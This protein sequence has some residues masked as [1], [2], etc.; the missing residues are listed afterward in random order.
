MEEKTNRSR[1]NI[2]DMQSIQAH[3]A[4]K[5][6]T[7]KGTSSS[8]I[9]TLLHCV[10]N[11]IGCFAENEVSNII[12]NSFPCFLIVNIDSSSMPGSH[13]L[14]LGI[15][16]NQIEIF[17]PLGFNSKLWPNKPFYLLNFLHNFSFSRKLIFSV[18]IQPT[19]SFLCGFYCLFYVL[20]RQNF[21]FRNIQRKFSRKLY[22]NDSILSHLFMKNKF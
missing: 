7:K 14:A 13:W 10:P 12:F 11:F 15:F 3:I 6:K 2:C 8:T 16:R 20:M 18:Q 22:K 9:T 21:S 1:E 17:D 19:S 5:F 4:K